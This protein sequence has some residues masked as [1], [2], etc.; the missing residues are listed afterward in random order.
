MSKQNSYQFLTCVPII[1][2]SCMDEADHVTEILSL[3]LDVLRHRKVRHKKRQNNELFQ[4][5]LG[6]NTQN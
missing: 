3:S 1:H 4:N 6:T 5:D 2:R